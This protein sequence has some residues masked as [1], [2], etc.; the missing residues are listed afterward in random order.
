MEKHNFQSHMQIHFGQRRKSSK[1]RLFWGTLLLILGIG[2]LLQSLDIVPFGEAIGTYWPVVL[3]VIG[4]FQL[5]NSRGDFVGPTLVLTVG[6]LLLL[7][8]MDLLPYGF[9]STFWPILLIVIGLSLLLRRRVRSSSIP[10]HD[11][12]VVDMNVVFG[13]A[14]EVS[15]SKEFAGGNISAVFGAVELDLRDAEITSSQA[16][17]DVSVVFGG[18]EIR[19][20]PNWSIITKGT[21]I[22]GS[23]ENKT[24]LHN[25]Q[26]A[27]APKLLLN[28]TAIFGGIEIRN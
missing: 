17:M 4:L 26:T 5:L 27:V 7:S 14:E 23:I 8:N 12:S 11:S 10:V 18:A 22:M 13:S 21:P 24:V 6:T 28:V 2:F 20:P 25:D 15:T 9:W 19:V 3:I 1:S 16:T